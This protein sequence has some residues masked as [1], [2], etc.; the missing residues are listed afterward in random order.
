MQS[1]DPRQ[2]VDALHAG[3]TAQIMQ[4]MTGLFGNIEDSL[5]E[6]AFGLHGQ[7]NLARKRQLGELMRDLRLRKTPFLKQFNRQLVD[8]KPLWFSGT[9]MASDVVEERAQAQKLA[10]KCNAHFGHL[11]KSI[12]DRTAHATGHEAQIR[13]LPLGPEQLV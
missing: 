12:A 6:I 10:A 7:E 3:A 1:M 13:S 11:L 4:L 2:A 5:F 9:P 8:A